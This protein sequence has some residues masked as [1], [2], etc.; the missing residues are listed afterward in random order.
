[1]RKTLSCVLGILVALGACGKPAVEI[2][3]PE[4][5]G[6]GSEITVSWT[7]TV[8]DGDRIVIR[9][10]GETEGLSIDAPTG[11]AVSVTLPLEDGTYEI[12]YLNAEGGILDTDTLTVTPNAYAFDLPEQ[13]PA[14]G[15]V[16]IHWSGPDHPGDYIT[17][18]PEGTPEG[19]WLD[20]EYTAVGNPI[21]LQAPLDPGLYEIRYSSDKADPNPTLYADTIRVIPVDHAVT[22]P[23]QVTAGSEFQVG[24]IGPDN[25]GDYITIVPAGT[26]EGIW[27]DYEYTASGNPCTL[28]APMEPGDYE[29]RY[30]SEQETPNRTMAMTTVSVITVEITLSAPGTVAAGS[31]FDV[32]WTG[33]DGEVDYI[34]IA[35]AGSEDGTFMSYSYTASG[36]PASLIAPDEPGDYEIRYASDRVTGT[37][38]RIPIR[39]E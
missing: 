15:T 24:W 28:T 38:A 4:E 2:T 10:A 22:A 8:A 23:E 1:M 29:I 35:P 12:A 21:L 25:P 37:F 32:E 13:V 9:L 39:V 16:E 33:P 31:T 6:A 19:D 3:A 20:Y 18:V 7:G 17:L 34:T 11:N 5:A 14:G 36:S 27:T 30:S 26:E